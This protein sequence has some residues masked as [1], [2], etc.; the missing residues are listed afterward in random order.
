[1]EAA[2]Q[3]IG[4][5][6][7]AP[8]SFWTEL[9]DQ[10]ADFFSGDLPLWRLSVPSVAAPIDLP[11]TQLIE[12]GGAQRWLRSDAPVDVIRS[13]AAQAGGSATLF[14]GSPESKAAASGAFAPLPPALLQLH[15]NLKSAFDP[16]GIFNPGRMYSE[17]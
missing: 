11:G 13:A 5:G 7:T 8:E 15:R 14:R 16:R 17:L 2:Q 12:W 4:A 6:G 10:K 1:V 9:R 3:K